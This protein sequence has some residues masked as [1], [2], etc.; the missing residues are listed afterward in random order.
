MLEIYLY[1]NNNNIHMHS[2]MCMVPKNNHVMFDIFFSQSKSLSFLVVFIVRPNFFSSKF[3]HNVC[4]MNHFWHIEKDFYWENYW[5]LVK[6]TVDGNKLFLEKRKYCTLG[7]RFLILCCTVHTAWT[8]VFLYH[9][10]NLVYTP[11]Y[12]MQ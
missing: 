7:R 10:Y 2:P 3:M 11:F 9:V 12:L 5:N 4:W 6:E 8:V 1:N